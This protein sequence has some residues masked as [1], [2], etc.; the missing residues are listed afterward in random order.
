MTIPCTSP[1]PTDSLLHH[2]S[3]YCSLPKAA[4]SL[5]RAASATVTTKQ[6]PRHVNRRAPQ[7]VAAAA[8]ADGAPTRK[9]CTSF[10]NRACCLPPPQA[11][12]AIGVGGVA[13]GAT[14]LRQALLQHLASNGCTSGG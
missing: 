13:L 6:H 8:A 9:I 11:N 10:V 1:L 2:P 4:I 3:R 5:I 14:V 12:S 7:Q